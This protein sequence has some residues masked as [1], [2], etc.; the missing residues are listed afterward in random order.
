L[1]LCE[2]LQL[3]A[4]E[5]SKEAH[6]GSASVRIISRDVNDCDPVFVNTDPTKGT[7]QIHLKENVKEG[8][9]VIQIEATDNDASPQFGKESIM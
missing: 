9:Q 8:E 1:V 6:T 2:T 7:Y 3:E 4:V 5:T